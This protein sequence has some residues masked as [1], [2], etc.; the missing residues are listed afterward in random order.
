MLRSDRNLS[1]SLF[2]KG[3]V[4][5]LF[6]TATLAWGVNLPAHTV[7]IKG[8]EV[9]NAEKG[10]FSDLGILDVLQI[11]GR[12]GR[13]QFDTSGEAMIV[14]SQ[15]KHSHYVQLLT[16]QIPIESKF[17][18]RL[19]DHLNA[20]IV[21][22]TVASLRDAVIWLSYTYLYIRMMKNPLVYGCTYHDK[23]LDP[24]LMKKRIDLITAAARR[25][26]TC[27]MI[28]FEERT[29]NFSTTELGRIASH[30]YIQHETIEHFNQHL[31]PNIS[32]SILFD[33]FSQ[34]REFQ[35][36]IVRDDEQ[37]EL[38]FLENDVCVLKVRGGSENSSGKVNI[39]LQ[40]YI[41]RFTIES[42]SLVSDMSYVSQNSDRIFRALFEISRS[43]GWVR[44]ATRLLNMCKMV[45][46]RLWSSGH[47]LAQFD[48]L[49]PT[50]LNKLVE[51]KMTVDQ[52]RD[53]TPQDLAGLTRTNPQTG[54]AIIKIANY[55]P[56]INIE[57]SMSPITRTVIR[58]TLTIT[59]DFKWYDRIHGNSEP[60]WIWVEDE[61]D[62]LIHSEYFILS[63]KQKDEEIKISFIIP[64]YA[65][66]FPEQYFINAFSD[67]WL[68]VETTVALNFREIILPDQQPPHTQ[69]LPLQPLPTDAL[70]NEEFQKLYTFTHFN[71]LQTQTFF[72][73]YH[74]D[75]NALIGA[76]TGSGKTIVAE[77]AMLR[78]FRDTNLKVVYIGPLKA[79]VRERIKDWKKRFSKLL[80]KKVLE[81]TGDY[82]PDIRALQTA[83][84]ILTTPEKWDGI[85][86]HWQQRSYVKK[87]GLM[88]IDEI[89]LLGEDRGP[90]LE[91]I[92]S[93]MRYVSSQTDTPIRFV[94]LSTALANPE[95]LGD[96]LG[97]K[98]PLGLYNFHPSM[99][100]VPIRIHL[101]G[102]AGKHYCPRMATM[103]KPCYAAIHTHSPTK[104]VLIFVS[105]R[106][107]TRLTALDLISYCVS[108][109][110]PKQF[111]SMSDSELESVLT[112]VE[113][114]NLQHTLAFGIGLHHAG[115]K[116]DDRGLVEQLFKECKIQIL[117]STSTLAWGVNLP[118][119]LVIIKGT[120]YY[121]PKTKRYVDFPVTDVLQ[122]MGRAGRPQYD[123][124]GIAVV[125]VE[126]SKKSFYK[127]FIREPFP[128]ESSLKS[129]LHDH[130]NAEICASTISSKQDAVDYLTWTYFFRRLEQNPT[131]YGLSDV[132]FESIN[133]Y[134][135]DLTDETLLD[136]SYA[137]CIQFD[138]DD[139]NQFTPTTFGRVASYYYLHYTT[140]E[141]FNSRISESCSLED[142]LNILCDT[143]EYEELPVR[144][145]EDTYNKSLAEEVR[146]TVDPYS[147]DSPHT[148]ANLLF[149]AHF[150]SLKF[151]IP[152][153]WTDLKSV[154]DQSI[155][156]LQAMVDVAADS[157]WLWTTL[158]TIELV[159][160]IMQGQW[161]TDSTLLQIPGMTQKILELFH[162][163]KVTC[164]PEFLALGKKEIAGIMDGLIPRDLKE[165]FW[166]VVET[167]PLVNMKLD[168][169][170]KLTSGLD[171]KLSVSLTRVSSYPSDKGAHTPKF[172]KK[173][174]EGWWLILG[175]PSTGELI[176]LRRVN[177]KGHLDTQ[178]S[179][180][181][182]SRPAFYHYYLYLM[183]DCY[184][185]LDQQYDVRFEVVKSEVDGENR[186]DQEKTEYQDEDAAW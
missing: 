161:S 119:H 29:G 129:A 140:M 166:S 32:D 159:Q 146:W 5:V 82:T 154:L 17:I 21:L 84:I 186:E 94:G 131:Y 80:G 173:K 38:R 120:E 136:L 182:P 81:L 88:V 135:S 44:L 64:I 53:S 181:A 128:V 10:G 116:N 168:L 111:L 65:D 165:T 123:T 114:T 41:S 61:H 183:C 68:N 90:I 30:Y 169:P 148:K 56:K 174:E 105:S 180:E 141:V 102:Y 47:P 179:F 62:E 1:E 50:L 52:I 48:L 8:T 113:D 89:H 133:R 76:P 57:P 185:G 46:K 4:N 103:N 170:P 100:P 70:K 121:D 19:A 178:L 172:P 98:P 139:S 45:D 40:T 7:I 145:N 109:E 27:K 18:D 86:R 151:W 122:M 147:Y 87:V 6:T 115:L 150:A 125:M 126:Q 31:N 143:A 167:L 138:E 184:L 156:I 34:V 26:D 42:F 157:G 35:N 107:Q 117:V 130:I 3:Y 144:H 160:M 28:R 60:W 22:G 39:L 95:D 97:I 163:R 79:L 78:I 11:F 43:N 83:D 67:R 55:F 142:L 93:R 152:D 177:C 63:K 66:P 36:I 75:S 106:R 155:R 72:T 16:H 92:V 99:R 13:P 124:E 91:V 54:K 2:M 96:W 171:Y 164:L 158:N 77:L 137:H 176:G 71:R 104:P 33:V 14:T 20:E 49:S 58:V 162:R 25:L 134:L 59:A 118:A 112:M 12:A 15:E 149:Q 127:K 24:F 51:K 110:T 175:D 23:E 69:L 132:N 73:M 85:S 101:Q 37:E 108:E 74:T 9:Y 153:Y